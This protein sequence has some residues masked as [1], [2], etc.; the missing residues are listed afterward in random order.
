[1]LSCLNLSSRFTLLWKTISV[2][3]PVASHIKAESH[4]D[5]WDKNFNGLC[6]YMFGWQWCFRFYSANLFCSFQDLTLNNNNK[7]F[8]IFCTIRSFHSNLSFGNFLPQ[9]GALKNVWNISKF[10]PLFPRSKVTCGFSSLSLTSRLGLPDARSL[11]SLS[12]QVF[13][14]FHSPV[15]L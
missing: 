3:I 12:R 6:T 1:M 8:K 4:K 2:D 9:R 11:S 7:N 14:L 13:F 5:V 15:N 10:K